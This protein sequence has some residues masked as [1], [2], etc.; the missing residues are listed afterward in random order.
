LSTLWTISALY[1]LA[2]RPFM[3]NCDKRLLRR[4][5]GLTNCMEPVPR[6]FIFT[7]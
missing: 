3:K 4:L 1:H 2:C 6:F 7:K 5:S